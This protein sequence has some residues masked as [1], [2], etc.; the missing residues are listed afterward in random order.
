MILELFQRAYKMISDIQIVAI[1]VTIGA[2]GTKL[3]GDSF[4]AV[5]FLSYAAVFIDTATKWIGI[6][7]RYY[8]DTTGCAISEVRGIQVIKGI[9]CEA[10]KPDYL[11]SR[12][13]GRILEKIF[14]Y[15]MIIALCHAAGKWIPVLD[16]FG[17]HFS[18]AAVFPAAA[19]I[20]IFLVELSSINENLKEMGQTG[21]S[22]M[23]NNL[24]STVSNKIFPK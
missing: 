16:I 2:M 12:Y 4:W 6:T 7:K 23:L 18:P 19:S 13:F 11:M 10:W 24:V 14:A 3:C 21:L 20:A 1:A 22:D 5:L 17:M 15:T 8:S 9:F